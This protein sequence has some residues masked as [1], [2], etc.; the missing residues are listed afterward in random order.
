MVEQLLSL[1]LVLVWVLVLILVVRDGRD[2]YSSAVGSFMR[3]E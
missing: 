2:K 1:L 3:D